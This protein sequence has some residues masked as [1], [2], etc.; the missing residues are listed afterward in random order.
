MPSK[1]PATVLTALTVTTLLL[2][3]C[4]MPGGSHVSHE[5]MVYVPPT[6]GT[7]VGR[8]VPISEANGPTISPTSGVS[9]ASI[10]KLQNEG[11]KTIVS[12]PS[13]GLGGR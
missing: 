11:T 1:T 7:M 5:G 4:T 2:L 13:M 12:N 9:Q 10:S 3:G 6:T 8:W